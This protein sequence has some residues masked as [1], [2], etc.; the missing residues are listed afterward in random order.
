M[1][2][3]KYLN[4][5][6]DSIWL[7][8]YDT[9]Q[10][11]MFIQYSQGKT[12]IEDYQNGEFIVYF[13]SGLPNTVY[14]YKNGKKEGEFIEYYN[15]GHRELVP[16]EKENDYDPDQYEEIISGHQVKIEGQYLQGKPE[17]EFNY[18]DE[19][20]NLIKKEIYENGKLISGN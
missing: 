18:Y 14:H 20:M 3:G 5:L 13:D 17:G 4:G 19:D 11:K 16:K 12:I 8:Y 10:I 1:Y 2:E 15:N 9:G 7:Y 6:K